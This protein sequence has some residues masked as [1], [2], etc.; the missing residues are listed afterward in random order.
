MAT[1]KKVANIIWPAK[2]FSFPTPNFTVFR[3]ILFHPVAIM[4]DMWPTELGSDWWAWLGELCGLLG[5]YTLHECRSLRRQRFRH[6]RTVLPTGNRTLA[7]PVKS[8]P[9]LRSAE[10]NDVTTLWEAESLHLVCSFSDN[11]LF[12]LFHGLPLSPSWVLFP[13][14]PAEIFSF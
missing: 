5:A 1:Q 2:L 13:F 8:L 7:C 4:C 14:T 12:H 9:I 10:C 11:V 6:H 3:T